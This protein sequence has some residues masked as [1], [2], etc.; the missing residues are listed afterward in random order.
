MSIRFRIILIIL[1]LITFMLLVE[2]ICKNELQL[3]YLLNL[4]GMLLVIL[5]IAIFPELLNWLA[6]VIGV[7]FPIN[8]VFFLGFCFVLMIVY[9]LTSAVSKLANNNKELAQKIALFEKKNCD[10]DSMRIGIDLT[11]LKHKKANGIG[12]YTEN[13]INVFLKLDDL[14]EYDINKNRYYYTV[15]SMQKYKNLITLLRMIKQL[16]DSIINL[17][18]IPVI[19]EF[20]EADKDNLEKKN[21]YIEIMN[22]LLLTKFV[23]NGERNSLFKYSDG[24]FLFPSI[25]EYFDSMQSIETM[26]LSTLLSTTI[27]TQ[28]V[29]MS[30]NK[31]NYISHPFISK[32]WMS[33]LKNI[34]WQEFPVIEFNEIKVTNI[35]RQHLDFFYEVNV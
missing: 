34:Q 16:K 18:R 13:L 32:E 25:P 26:M 24:S 28:P 14:N 11:L 1:I 23:T 30:M 8:L 35:V 7:E 3:K 5:I 17:L 6:K 22:N 12:F 31:V 10:G 4:L 29:K 21:I 33:E 2:Q 27:E 19:S 20:S 9:S 15:C